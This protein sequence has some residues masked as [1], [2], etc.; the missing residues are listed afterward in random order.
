ME[1]IENKVISRIYGHGRGW[2]FSQIDFVDLGKRST[3]DWVL[4]RL[5]KRDTISKVLRGVYYYPDESLLLKEQLPVEIP[6]WEDI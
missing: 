5:E 3:I 4:Y 6:S 1:S 2:A